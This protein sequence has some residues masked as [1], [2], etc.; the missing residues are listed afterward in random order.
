MKVFLK[1]LGAIFIAMMV[2]GVFVYVPHK[3]YTV[4][5]DEPNPSYSVSP[6][7]VLMSNIGV[8]RNMGGKVEI[9]YPRMALQTLIFGAAAF[10][11][12]SA[13]NKKS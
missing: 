12:F 8:L 7:W 4:F 13:A 9:D 11:C 5:P 6:N 3:A 2:I 10:F 1:V